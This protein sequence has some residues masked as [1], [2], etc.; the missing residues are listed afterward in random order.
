[1]KNELNFKTHNASLIGLYILG[2]AIIFLPTKNADEYTFLAFLVV[3]TMALPF[4]MVISFLANKLFCKQDLNL[5]AKIIAIVVLIGVAVFALFCAADTL[6][7]F[8]KFISLYVLVDTNP[9]FIVILFAVCVF[10]FLRVKHT[11][12]LKFSILAFLFSLAVT[13]FFFFATAHNYELRNI[14]IFKLPSHA[15]FFKQAKPYLKE[16]L[17]PL[18]LIP[19]LNLSL[20]GKLRTKTALVGIFSGIS[21]LGICVMGAVLLFGAE[22]SGR[23]DFPFASAVSTVTMGRLFT[24][25]DGLSYFVYF[26]TALI[27][28]VVCANVVKFCLSKFNKITRRGDS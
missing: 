28:T 2:N 25:M 26:A 12:I 9:M 23:L 1:M 20:F 11:D 21:A 10:V 5:P 6:K 27:K 14:F 19:F 8:L 7:D 24:R 4:Y 13:L 16:I 22:L 3:S 17:F 15:E 18:L